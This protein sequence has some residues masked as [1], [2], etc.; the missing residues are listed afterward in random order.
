MYKATLC[1][2]AQGASLQSLRL[3]L[4]DGTEWSPKILFTLD[5]HV[6]AHFRYWYG[7]LWDNLSVS[8]ETLGRS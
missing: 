5:K 8:I 2:L 6:C 7:A 4:D 1:A 3:H